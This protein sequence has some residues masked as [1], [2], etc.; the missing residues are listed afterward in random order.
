[1]TAFRPASIVQNQV[2]NGDLLRRADYLFK[3]QQ[4]AGEMAEWFNA[5]AWKA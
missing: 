4:L 3:F 2:F 5:H 1:M